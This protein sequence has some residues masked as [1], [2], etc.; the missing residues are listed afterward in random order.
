M[1]NLKEIN[2]AIHQKDTFRHL[3]VTGPVDQM[4]FTTEKSEYEFD[5]VI[6]FSK[7]HDYSC[8]KEDRVFFWLYID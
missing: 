5:E 6:L 1:E 3:Y 7:F 2:D 4:P 8:S